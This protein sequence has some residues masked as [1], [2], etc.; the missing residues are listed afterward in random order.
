MGKIYEDK[1]FFQKFLFSKLHGGKFNYLELGDEQAVHVT[2]HVFKPKVRETAVDFNE[3]TFF[4]MKR[5]RVYF[6]DE[7]VILFKHLKPVQTKEIRDDI[8]SKSK[9]FL[10]V[11]KHTSGEERK[12]FYMRGRNF[13]QWLL[14]LFTHEK[15]YIQIA[16]EGIIHRREGKTSARN[17]YIPFDKVDFAT[18][19]ASYFLLP[20]LFRKERVCVSGSLN[21]VTKFYIKGSE[22]KVVR[23]ELEDHIKMLAGRLYHPNI[24]SGVDNKKSYSLY[25]LD[26]KIVYLHNEDVQ[27]IKYVTKFSCKP[28]F[29]LF[30]RVATIE[31][32]SE[33]NQRTGNSNDVSIIFPG[34]F[35]FSWGGIKRKL[36]KMRK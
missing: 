5:S 29:S 32:V 17:S 15:E 9:N 22:A 35:F 7:N 24:F 10:E 33:T 21:F 30:K 13:G 34:I 6:G 1:S 31:G 28:I 3:L 25:V 11:F 23:N 19:Q 14:C 20:F 2:H 18:F 27:V 12:K 8:M 36:K 4:D 16:D 26:D